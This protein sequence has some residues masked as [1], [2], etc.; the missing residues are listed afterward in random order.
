MIETYKIYFDI[1]VTISE[2]AG[3]VGPTLLSN[4]LRS[5]LQIDGEKKYRKN[6]ISNMT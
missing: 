3:G 4:R 2:Q 5:Q 1:H 6:Y